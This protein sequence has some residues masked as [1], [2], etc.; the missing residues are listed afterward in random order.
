MT[1]RYITAAAVK[2][3]YHGKTLVIPGS[4]HVSALLAARSSFDTNGIPVEYFDHYDEGFF[5]NTCEF[6]NREIAYDIADA[7][8]QIITKNDMRILYS[9]NY[10]MVHTEN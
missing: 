2:A 1:N 6:V 8:G 3:T 5:T 7:A 10:K 9:Y 4:T